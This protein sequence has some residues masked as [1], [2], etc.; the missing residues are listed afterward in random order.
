MCA[1]GGRPCVEEL[2]LRVSAAAEGHGIGRG[3]VPVSVSVAI[4]SIR[5]LDQQ[6][7]HLRKVGQ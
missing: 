2:Y 5:C 4:P 6:M 1:A 7:T 3:K